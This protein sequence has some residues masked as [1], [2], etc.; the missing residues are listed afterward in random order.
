MVEKGLERETLFGIGSM[1]GQLTLAC[2]HL[3][4]EFENISES[5]QH[6]LSLELL[7]VG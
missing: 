7:G 3:H 1:Q 4:V 6:S 5:V 2:Q